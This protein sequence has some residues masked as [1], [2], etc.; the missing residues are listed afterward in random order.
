MAM[1]LE[2]IVP[3]GRSLDEYINMFSLTPADCQTSILGAGDGPASF[4]AEGSQ[5]G[6]RI[7]S[8]DPIYTFSAEQIQQR[9]DQVVDGIIEQIRNTP[10]DW[11]WSYHRSPDELRQHRERA[12]QLF[13]ADYEQGRAEQRYQPGALPQLDM[14]DNAFD[15]SLCSHLLFL[16]SEH[17]DQAFHLAAIHELLRVSQ[18]V[19]IFPLLTLMLKRSPHLEPVMQHFSAQGYT[20]E[21]Q[22]VAYELQRGG[23]EMLRITRPR[24]QG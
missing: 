5:L 11:V 6:Y 23:N 19:R 16:Y 14:A 20:C 8:V 15:L 4:N 12:L 18:E 10:D 1:Q 9:F 22:P 24:A 2:Q 3:F 7:T 17:L 13:C 21:I